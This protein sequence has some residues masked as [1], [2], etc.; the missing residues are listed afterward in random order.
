M[1]TDSLLGI[2][3]GPG[4]SSVGGANPANVRAT[5]ETQQRP[6]PVQKAESARERDDRDFDLKSI[7]AAARKV[8]E[9]VGS[10]RSELTFSVDTDSGI[11]IVKVIDANTKE[12]IRQI[13][14]REIIQIAQA[15]DKLQGLF[16]KSKA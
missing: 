14:S 4:V 5:A 10:V 12:V 16:V 13:P 6:A 3:A 2:V 15:L 7:E 9:F 8:A 11:N 1:I